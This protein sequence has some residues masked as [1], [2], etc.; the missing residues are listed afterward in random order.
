MGGVTYDIISCAGPLSPILLHYRSR[1]FQWPN[2]DSPSLPPPPPPPP[3]PPI[4]SFICPSFLPDSPGVPV[5]ATSK[6]VFR[7]FSYVD[8]TLM[9]EE[10][11]ISLG[12]TQPSTVHMST[13]SISLSP[14]S[15][16]LPTCLIPHRL[17]L[18]L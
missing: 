2:I 3:P 9:D 17:S 1:L 15:L 4:H 11:R 14:S 6:E 16:L 8:P 10:K 7:G 12:Q 5:S 13:V 18:S